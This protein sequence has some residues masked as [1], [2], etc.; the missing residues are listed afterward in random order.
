M[1]RPANYSIKSL[2]LILLFLMLPILTWA[3]GGS[4][5]TLPITTA[6]P[7]P[8][9]AAPAS[10]ITRTIAPT[11][12]PTPTL[13]PRPS[14]VI[15]PTPS[16]EPAATDPT[17]I[18]MF[19]ALLAAILGA[20]TVFRNQVKKQKS[21]SDR[22]DS[23]KELLEQKK[24]EVEEM[25]KNWPQDKIKSII[26]GKVVEQLEK[27]EETRKILAIKEKYDKAQKIIEMLQ[28]KYDLCKLEVA[29]FQKEKIVV[30]GAGACGLMAGLEL[31]KAGKDVVILEARDRTGGR[32]WPLDR[33][34]FGYFAQGGAEFV[35]GPAPITKKL[36]KEAGLT[37]ESMKGEVWLA[38]KGDLKKEESFLPFDQ[39][40]L[41]QKL[42]ELKEDMSIADFFDKYLPE[43][44]FS[45]L[46]KYILNMVEG[47]DAAE[48]KKISTFSLREE[49]L[50]EEN[51]WEQGK[52]IKEGYGAL[53]GYLR[54]EC[55]KN[56]VKISLNKKVEKLEIIN[57]GVLI[58]CSD[59]QKL[60]ADKAIVTISLPLLSAIE[61]KPAIPQKLKAISGVGFGN[62]IKI[63]LR[64]K[65]EWWKNAQGKDLTKL[66]FLRSEETVSTWWTQYPESQ[67][68]LTGWLAGPDSLKFK[69]SLSEEILKVSLDSLSNIFSI[70]KNELKNKLVNCHV[71]NWPADPYAQGAYSYSMVG[72]E[73]AY[74][75]LRKPVDGRIFFSGEALCSGKESATVEGALASGLE[76]ARKILKKD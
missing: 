9:Q 8:V 56:G 51:E 70:D 5:G 57:N 23:I 41:H 20:Y 66:G 30:V 33:S 45:H 14:S 29:G 60:E 32:I 36:I 37:F 6:S 24:K 15:T 12:I 28:K 59:G 62:V 43:E 54:S 42:K 1:F 53:L 69:D 13:A 11:P 67:P 34:E 64:F 2:V 25:I 39:T 38:Q 31:A 68:V 71:F 10:V 19:T 55:Q 16:L 4:N 27:N 61:F 21:N 3:Q 40:I 47:Y 18:L 72:S 63:L 48:P 35:H 76:T 17:P 26:E 75:E 22:C 73:R 7:V 50:S 65:D 46:K 44:K 49:W 74:A 58:I 52:I